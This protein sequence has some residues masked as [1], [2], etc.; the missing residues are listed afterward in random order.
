MFQRARL[1]RR[2]LTT[3][4]LVAV[5]IAFCLL[6]DSLQASVPTAPVSDGPAFTYSLVGPPPSVQVGESFASRVQYTSSVSRRRPRR[7]KRLFSG[8]DFLRGQLFRQVWFILV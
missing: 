2:R 8:P 1:I 6:V 5:V 4:L 7:D 3:A